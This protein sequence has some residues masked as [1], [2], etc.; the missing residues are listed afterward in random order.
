MS[1][2]I[3][4]LK[5]EWE[6]LAHN[7]VFWAVL[8]NDDKT[9]GQW[10]PEEF[11]ERGERQIKR[12]MKRLGEYDIRRGRAL[13]FGCGPGRLTFPLCQYFEKVEG[14]DISESTI[15]L[16]ETSVRRPVNAS[17]HLNQ[18]DDLSIFDDGS[19]DF[20][21]SLITL[22]H[23]PPAVAR[24]YLIEFYRILDHGGFLFFQIPSHVRPVNLKYRIYSLL[25][26][27]LIRWLY[28]PFLAN[29]PG[30]MEMNGI[31]RKK[32]ELFLSDI[33]FD[34]V[35]VWEDTSAGEIWSSYRYLFYKA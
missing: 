9:G 35:R 26:N 5:K 20:I 8:S 28:K 27:R 4:R 29:K 7:D 32:M 23:M 22:Q 25:P 34:V 1:R 12:W 17:F 18:K 2:K 21:I 13:D 30:Y 14:V 6:E 19:F 16:A 31:R 10:S 24:S 3:N 33:G 11:Y 15:G